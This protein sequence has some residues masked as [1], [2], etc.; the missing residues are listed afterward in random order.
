VYC[1]C[2]RL[3]VGNPLEGGCCGMCCGMCQTDSL[4]S[5][6]RRVLCSQVLGMCQTDTGRRV[7]CRGPNDS[8][9]IE[10]VLGSQTWDLIVYHSSRIELPNIT[11]MAKYY[12]ATSLRWPKSEDQI[13]SNYTS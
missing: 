10:S 4:N 5:T 6:G 9:E 12:S 8:L 11:K 1:V 7:L 3:T 13:V 2:A